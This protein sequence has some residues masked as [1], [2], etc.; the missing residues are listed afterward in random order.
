LNGSDEAGAQRALDASGLM[1]F[2][3][4]GAL[5]ARTVANSLRI[6]PLD[7]PWAD[8]PRFWRE[9]DIEAHLPLFKDYAPT[10]GL[11]KGRR[12]PLFRLTDQM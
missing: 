8:G 4:D 9:E 11:A 10:A 2:S 6:A 3:I 1:R 5:H 12:N 7:M